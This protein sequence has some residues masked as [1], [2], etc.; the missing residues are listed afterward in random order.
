MIQAVGGDPGRERLIVEDRR[1][2][3]SSIPAGDVLAAK[4]WPPKRE[5]T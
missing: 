5:A 1:G 2:R 3:R 4:V